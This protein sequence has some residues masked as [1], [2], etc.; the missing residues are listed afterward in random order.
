MQAQWG[1]VLLFLQYNPDICQWPRSLNSLSLAS[2]SM[3]GIF[4]AL[5]P[6]MNLTVMKNATLLGSIKSIVYSYLRGFS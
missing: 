1:L 6:E 3:T 5:W 2:K 4:L